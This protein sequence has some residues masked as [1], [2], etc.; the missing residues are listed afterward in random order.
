MK[1]VPMPPR[2]EILPRD[3]RGYPIPWN[4]LIGDDGKP[5][6]TANDSRKHM[7][8]L[9][10]ALCPICGVRLGKWKW[11]VGGPK[12]AFDPHGWFIDLPG[13][14]DCIEYA[15]QVCPY[16]S[17]RHYDQTV[18]LIERAKLPQNVKVIDDTQDP[19]RPLL[20]VMVASEWMEVMA[21][22]R[23][24]GHLPVVRPKRPWLGVKYWRHGKR[25]SDA[26]GNELVR[27]ALFGP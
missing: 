11:F 18:P 23:G 21:S 24:A 16:L 5:I 20:F 1:E 19:T 6:F 17:V 25:L 13:H 14:D 15:L 10:E 3:E 27:Q 7:Q 8:A 4:I 12:S 26:E 22:G 9:N 2:I